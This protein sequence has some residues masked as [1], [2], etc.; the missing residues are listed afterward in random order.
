MSVKYAFAVMYL[1]LL[2]IACLLS[3]HS[4]AHS[5]IMCTSRHN[6]HAFVDLLAVFG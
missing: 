5:K 4:F 3:F 2:D 1:I 6:P